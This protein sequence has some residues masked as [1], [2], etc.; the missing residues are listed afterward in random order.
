VEVK[1]IVRGICCLRPGIK[2]FSENIEVR[3][4][5]GRFLEHTRVY[6]FENC[7]NPE[8]FASSA[9]VMTRNMF[10]RVEVCFPIESSKHQVRILHDLE[11]YLQDTG[12]A[13]ILQSDGTYSKVAGDQEPGFMAQS[14]LLEELRK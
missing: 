7:G 14:Q 12:N 10:S 2:G 1:L 13:W 6:F 11:L 3:S 5:I 8:I 4:I 9:D